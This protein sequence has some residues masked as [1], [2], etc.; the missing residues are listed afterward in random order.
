MQLLH[1]YFRRTGKPWAYIDQ[2]W[3]L[4]KLLDWYGI[5]MARSTLN[6]NLKRLRENGFIDTTPRHYTDPA[7]GKFVC[8]V[9]LYKITK[10]LRSFFHKVAEYFKRIG[11]S[12][13]LEA[14]KA[15]YLPVVGRITTKEAAWVEMCQVKR[16]RGP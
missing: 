10:K 5:R 6:Y 9:T 3:M 15:G 1:G 4:D 8:R 13:S 11:W 14:L 12:P 16:R 7:T 2:Q